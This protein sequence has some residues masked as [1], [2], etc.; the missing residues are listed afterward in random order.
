MSPQAGTVLLEQIAPRLKA[1]VPYIK[2]VGIE[3]KDEL[4]S[5][6]IVHGCTSV[7]EQRTTG[8]TSFSIIGGILHHPSP[9]N[10]AVGAISA[11]RTDVMGS[12]TQLDG[13][14]AVLSMETEIAFDPETMEAIRL[15]EFLSCSQDDPSTRAARN[16]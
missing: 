11:A 14:T 13:K 9:S 5:G 16:L 2:P 6:W 8:E 1:A 12:G 4:F 3:D 15:G 10:Q 7:G